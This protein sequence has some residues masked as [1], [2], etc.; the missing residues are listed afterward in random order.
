MRKRLSVHILF[1]LAG[2]LAT[3]CLAFAYEC[4]LTAP[5]ASCNVDNA[6]Y[7]SVS[8]Q[9][10]G[11]GVIDSFVRISDGS[12]NGDV[13][14]GYNTSGRD[15]NFDENSSPTFTHD[16][17]LAGTEV[18][19]GYYVFHLDINQN[20]SSPLLSLDEVQIFTSSVASQDVS[21]FGNLHGAGTLDIAGNLVYQLD[22][23]GNNE[24]VLNYNI[25]GGSGQGDMVLL[26]P[27]SAFGNV[28]PNTT[29][30]YLYSAF[31]G[32]GDSCIGRYDDATPPNADTPI[33]S[34]CANN[35]GYE[36]WYR[37]LAPAPEVPEPATL[38]LFGT[39]LIALGAKLRR[40]TKKKS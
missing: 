16:I 20:G 21:T 29:Y 32:M 37:V 18:T 31:G 39:G 7:T 30:V 5:G 38:T 25:N 14:S 12:I 23:T 27:V 35:D 36:E 33:T 1:L 2:I 6:I 26:V 8:P 10:Q 19:N 17:L 11:S 13:V 9:P 3:S 4:D 34:S 15:L 24:I 22:A 40:R 28:D